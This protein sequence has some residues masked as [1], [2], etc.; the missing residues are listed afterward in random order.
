MRTEH[1]DLIILTASGVALATILA[2]V[3]A[4]TANAAPPTT[5]VSVTAPTIVTVTA[6]ASSPDLPTPQAGSQAA[7]LADLDHWR[8]PRSIGG[9]AEVQIGIG[10][11]DQLVAGQTLG[12]L[13]DQIASELPWTLEQAEHVVAAARAEL[14][15][16]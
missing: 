11:C 12:A 16:G 3:A 15:H 6:L 10:V 13:A 8:I 5:T 4:C 9:A 2:T 1:R 14:C 7:F